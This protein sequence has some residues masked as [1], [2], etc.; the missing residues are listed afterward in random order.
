MLLNAV[1]TGA[2]SNALVNRSMELRWDAFRFHSVHAT[3]AK[4]HWNSVIIS[5]IYCKKCNW[6]ISYCAD[7]QLDM[8]ALWG[9]QLKTCVWA[10]VCKPRHFD[11]SRS[12]NYMQRVFFCLS[13]L[14]D[15]LLYHSC[16]NSGFTDW[17]LNGNVIK[18]QVQCQW[19][20]QTVELLG[21]LS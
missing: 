12:Y 14:Y 5:G 3:R 9:M 18:M 6:S 7:A 10:W 13:S 19:E 15:L 2:Q 4:R 8:S 1:D 17:L 11:L 21:S 20:A 16:Q